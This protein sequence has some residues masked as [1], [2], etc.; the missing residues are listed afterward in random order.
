MSDEIT[1]PKTIDRAAVVRDALVF[2]VKLALDGIID[3]IMLPVSA[4]AAIG[5]L[6]QGDDSFY[7]AVRMGAQF[8]RRLNLWGAGREDKDAD[9]DDDPIESLARR[10]DVEIRREIR[11]RDLKTSAKDIATEVTRRVNEINKRLTDLE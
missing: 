9:E 5:S 8:D 10:I 1:P 3:L 7:R 2:Q 4:V 6:V 11:E